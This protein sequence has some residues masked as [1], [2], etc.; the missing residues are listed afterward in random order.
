MEGKVNSN[1]VVVYDAY[2]SNVEKSNLIL[3]KYSD[4]FPVP[5]RYVGLYLE[6]DDSYIFLDDAAT[7]KITQCIE[8]NGGICD[9]VFDNLRRVN[10]WGGRGSNTYFAFAQDL[11]AHEARHPKKGVTESIG[12]AKSRKTL[13]ESFVE[14]ISLSSLADLIYAYGNDLRVLH[15][16]VK[17]E[18]FKSVH[19]ALNE[20][21]DT[22]FDAYDTVAEL[23]IARGEEVKNPSTVVSIIKPL[24]ARTFNCEEAIAIARDEGLKV[25]D[26]VCSIEGYDKA[27][28]PALDNIT[29]SLDKTLNYV[30]T[31]WAVAADAEEYI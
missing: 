13:K 10:S 15:L 6:N 17:G 24:E 11:K 20:L 2:V 22:I 4:I 26:A 1:R 8:S 18:D 5:G 14:A 27:V 28:Q 31:R 7:E 9:V 25:L 12:E 30:F 19:E 21:Y 3:R 23:A 29:V 16:N